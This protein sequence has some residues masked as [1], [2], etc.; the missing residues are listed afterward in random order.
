MISLSIGAMTSDTMREL[1]TANMDMEITQKGAVD[2]EENLGPTVPRK[3]EQH[4]II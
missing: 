2:E 4:S 1:A 3:R